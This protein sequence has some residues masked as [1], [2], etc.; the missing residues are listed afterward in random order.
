[1]NNHAVVGSNL[2]RLD[3]DPPCSSRATEWLLLALVVIQ[4]L[5]LVD[6]FLAGQTLNW[7]LVAIGKELES[8][9]GRLNASEALQTRRE[10]EMAANKAAGMPLFE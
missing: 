3:G 2:R 5:R 6:S 9:G 7:N 8:I 4:G 1:M 10:Q